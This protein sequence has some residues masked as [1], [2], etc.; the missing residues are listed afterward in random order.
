[1]ASSSTGRKRKYDVFLSF[2]G[3][4]TRD[5]FT[6]H[7]YDALCRKKVK[8]FIDNDLQRGEEI[9]PAL[10]RTIEESKISVIIFSKNYASSPWCL[11]EMSKIIECNDTYGQI[12]LPVFYHIDPSLL[13]EQSGSFVD[14]FIDAEKN[15]KEKMEKVLRWRVDL[16]KAAS[17][18]GWDSQVIRPEAKLVNDIMKHILRKL[19]HASFRDSKGL[20]GIDSHIEQIRKLLCFG[21]PDVPIVGIWGMGGIGKTTIAEAIFYS[22]SSEYEGCCF[23]KNIKEESKRCGLDFL[24]QKLLFE[25]LEEENLHT[26]SPNMGSISNED[27]LQ[28]TKVFLLLDDVDDVDQL[29]AL[30]RRSNLGLGSRVIVTSRDRQVLKNV[31]DDVYEV[32]GLNED[33]ALQLFS[34]YAFKKNCPLKDRIDLS[35]KVVNYAQGNPLVLKVLGSYL[36]DR[37]K[38]D[39]ESALNKLGRGPHSQICNVLRI[40]FDTLD[41]EEKSVFLFLDIACFL[42]GTKLISKIDFVKRILDGCGFSADIGISVLVDRCLIT[43]LENKLGIH[44]L[45]LEMAHEIVR[46]ESVAKLGKRCRLWNP[47]DILQVL[48]KNLGT[49]K[50]GEGIF[51][52]AS[53]KEELN[54]CSRAFL[55]TWNNFLYCLKFTMLRN[56][57]I[58]EK[59]CNLHH[60]LWSFFLDELG[61]FFPSFYHG[62]EFLS[63]ELRYLHWDGYPLRSMPSNF[64]AEKL[65][66][67]NLA[68]SNVKQLWTGVQLILSGCS[69]ITQFPDVSRTIKKLILDKTA[70]EEIPSSVQYLCELE[71]LSM[72]QCTSFQILPSS[73]CKLKSLQKL[74]LSGCS[75]FQC[76][77]EVSE[78]MGSLRYLYLDGTAIT[79]LPS[80]IENLKGLSSLEVRNCENLSI[81]PEMISGIEYFLNMPDRGVDIQNLRKL[82]LTNC[83]FLNVPYGIGCLF[84]LEALDLSG[85]N[86]RK[87]PESINKLIELQY[88]GLRN[89]QD[90]VSLPDLPPQLA[91]LDAHNCISLIEVSF[92]STGVKGNIFEFFF[93]NCDMLGSGARHNIMEYALTKFMRYAKRLNNQIPSILAGESSFCINGRAI[94]RWFGHQSEGFSTTMKLP[95]QWANI[96]FLGF[97][98][99]VII[100]FDGIYFRGNNGF[101][102]RCQYHFKNEYREC[103]DLHSY[104]GGWYGKRTLV[105]CHPNPFGTNYRMFFG[106]D[107]CVD[108]T[109][110]DHFSKYRELVVEFYPEDMDGNPLHRCKVMNC[111]VRLLYSEEEVFCRCLQTEEKFS[112][113]SAFHARYGRSFACFDVDDEEDTD[114]LAS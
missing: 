61:I 26:L 10:L 62:L 6:S 68:Y 69:N 24:K 91:T 84:S 52:D 81:L 65:V 34:L 112:K 46:Q 83:S 77:P 63:D 99:C 76:F 27:R 85:N 55:R 94:P 114:T 71:E 102:I 3:E 95:S 70:I 90:L 47:I 25:T 20:V 30:I 16:M 32:E 17:I 64:Q 53:T 19:N 8:T 29:D 106:Y 98:L 109:K 44:D 57:E 89:C 33:E 111:G 107:P 80:P 39:W 113:I 15:F 103:S 101:Q 86:F 4:D 87:I 12:V 96:K 37:R 97:T 49:E 82:Y 41:D 79:K 43:V 78:V 2:R 38:R 58:T 31:V 11:D 75:M 48:T 23:L 54:L 92:D 18:S 45:L 100:K 9:T 5:N 110:D 36:F 14:V 13:Q 56:L 73:I 28:C 1:M 59:N 60:G 40:S 104:F 88:L 74:N 7:L 67:L 51:L 22:A 66:E 108:A 105:T 72:Q 93:T 21:S 35:N 42:R 50:V